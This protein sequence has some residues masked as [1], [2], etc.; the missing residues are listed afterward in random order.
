MRPHLEVNDEKMFYK[1]LDKSKVYFEYGSGGSTYQASI[2]N[3]INKIYSVESDKEW[4]NKLEEMIQSNNVTYF[5]NEM[6]TLP[7]TWGYPG[8]NSNPIQHKNYSDYIRNI[9]K[10]EQEKIDLVFI[11]GR[12]RVACCLK[13]FDIINSDCFIA[14]DDFLNRIE[15]H[16]VLNFYNIIER[17]IDNRMVILQKKKNISS[18]PEVIIKKYELIMD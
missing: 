15:Y 9:S 3:N 7:N 17:T 18:I 14:F 5:F 10:E 11:D 2:R 8:Q 1:Y 16:I 6:N 4:Q 12:F 13:C